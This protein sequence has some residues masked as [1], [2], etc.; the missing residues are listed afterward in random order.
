MTAP[1]IGII[2]QMPYIIPNKIPLKP[3]KYTIMPNA[4]PCNTTLKKVERNTILKVPL[5]SVATW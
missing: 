1:I 4:V 3:K 5:T 2:E